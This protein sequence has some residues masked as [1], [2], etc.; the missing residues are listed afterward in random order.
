[1][2]F[3]IT[4]AVLLFVISL[5][6]LLPRIPIVGEIGTICESFFSIHLVILSLA[7][8]IAFSFIFR[9]DMNRLTAIGLA[10]SVFAAVALMVPFVTLVSE[11]GSRKV[12]LS[13]A[14]MLRVKFSAGRPDPASSVKYTTVDGQDLYVQISLP[15]DNDS[16]G[17]RI[18]VVL[19]HGGGYVKGA[20]NLEP[21]WA[22]F[23]NRRGYVV[24][25][26]DYRLAKASY[27]TWD[28]AAPDIATAIVWIGNHAAKYNV[29]MSRLIL[30]GSSA[31]G[32]L[33]LQT[34][35]GINDG[36]VKSYE[37][38]TVY[39]PKAV[40]ALYPCQDLTGLWKKNPR[41]FGI[42]LRGLSEA[43]IGG[44][45]E[46]YPDRYALVDA[47]AHVSS[48]SPPTLMV[49]GRNDH[50]LPFADQKALADKLS[51]A[52]VT[53]VFVALPFN[54]H[55]FTIAVGSLGSQISFKV[56]NDFLTKLEAQGHPLSR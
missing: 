23:F 12:D 11:A 47:G 24:F 41:L 55:F 50:L 56:A 46:Q 53:N 15:S 1:V 10:A 6:V 40:V 54:D 38:G 27:F 7:A 48:S 8:S 3:L 43:F 25:D 14:D 21:A 44:T 19:I 34:A 4:I 35:Y 13:W 17:S 16:A 52:G 39:P 2:Y 42:G 18:P 31:G 30:A 5:G 32:G 33:A 37:V 36:T 29:D 49:V 20:R 51:A 9:A 22:R 45:P 26:V 28:K